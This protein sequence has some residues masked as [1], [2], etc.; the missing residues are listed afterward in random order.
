MSEDCNLPEVKLRESFTGIGT[1]SAVGLF[2]EIGAVERF[3]C[4]YPKPHPC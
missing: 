1:Y 4:P 2:L 3:P